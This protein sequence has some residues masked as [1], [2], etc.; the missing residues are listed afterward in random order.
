MRITPNEVHVDDPSF[1]DVLFTGPSHVRRISQNVDECLLNR[2]EIGI[3]LLLAWP[4]LLKAVC[5]AVL[6]DKNKDRI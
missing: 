6:S 5:V 2:N 4:V 1:V 3:L